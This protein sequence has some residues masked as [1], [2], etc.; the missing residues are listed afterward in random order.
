MVIISYDASWRFWSEEKRYSVRCIMYLLLQ[1]E[2]II[3]ELKTI[4]W[5][6]LSRKVT[7][8]NHASERLNN[9]TQIRTLLQELEHKGLWKSMN[10]TDQATI[11]DSKDEILR[12][13]NL[14]ET[15]LERAGLW[16]RSA[17][18]EKGEPEN[19]VARSAAPAVTLEQIA[20]HAK[21]AESCLAQHKNV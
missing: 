15:Q 8:M 5:S 3:F 16:D 10:I 6:I 19:E 14:I 4:T 20:Q 7:N 13:L 1:S 18:V 2:N 17:D 21:I 9:V 11:E 12:L